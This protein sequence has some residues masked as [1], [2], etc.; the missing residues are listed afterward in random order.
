MPMIS[1][2]LRSKTWRRDAPG[3]PWRRDPAEHAALYRQSVAL[4]ATLQ[5]RGAELASSDYLPYGIAFESTSSPGRW[6]SSSNTSGGLP[7]R[8]PLPAARDALRVEFA[9]MVE[10]LAS[11]PRVLC[12]RDYHSAT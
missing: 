9:I 2:S 1:A 3:A 7:R 4:V 8:G 5:R 10:T 11:E 6:T 12:H